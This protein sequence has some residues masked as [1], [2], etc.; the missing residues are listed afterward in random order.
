MLR[1]APVAS[2]PHTP[3]S[4]QFQFQKHNSVF[5]FS[6]FPQPSFVFSFFFLFVCFA[7][8][9]HLVTCIK[10]L[11]WVLHSHNFDALGVSIQT[12][13][14]HNRKLPL[15]EVQQ[16]CVTFSKK[17]GERKPLCMGFDK[18]HILLQLEGNKFPNIVTL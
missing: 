17:F 14:G 13:V 12:Q 3:T 18:K 2:T 16:F 4:I 11:V 8:R 6:F 7:F 1:R 5:L 9:Y 10:E 15:K